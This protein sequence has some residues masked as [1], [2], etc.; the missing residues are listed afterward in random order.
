MHMVQI[1][2]CIRHGGTA[3]KKNVFKKYYYGSVWFEFVTRIKYI[4]V[5]MTNII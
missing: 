5:C 4:F 2:I 3:L 1:Y